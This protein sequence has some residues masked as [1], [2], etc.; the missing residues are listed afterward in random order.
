MADA[1]NPLFFYEE[2]HVRMSSSLQDDEIR[3]GISKRLRCIFIKSTCALS[4]IVHNIAYVLH[5]LFDRLNE[6]N[7]G[8][9]A[10]QDVQSNAT[11]DQSAEPRPAMGSHDND[12]IRVLVSIIDYLIGRLAL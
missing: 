4:A 1:G 5:L 12:G 11:V 7:R 9:N 6:E 10:D 8:R 3:C 2:G